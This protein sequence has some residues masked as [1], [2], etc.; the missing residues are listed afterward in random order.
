[1]SEGQTSVAGVAQTALPSAGGLLRQA[2]EAAGLHIAALAVS[3][4]M[5][6]R[7]IEALE[8]DRWD[9]LPDLAFV[10]ALAASVCRSL[11]IDPAPVLA[12]L[13]PASPARLRDS[14]S[15][16]GAS[17]GGGSGRL[18]NHGLSLIT[19]PLGAASLLLLAALAIYFWPAVES[20]VTADSTATKPAAPPQVSAEQA[21]SMSQ[22]AAPLIA[23]IAA[24]PGV[25]TPAPL[26]SPATN[27]PV[28][29]AMASVSFK[30]R[31]VS[32]VE[33]TDGREAVL[34]R[35][36]LQA[37]ENVAAEGSS[38]LV[39]VIGRANAVEVTVRGQ[40]FDVQAHA[41]DNVARF[42]VK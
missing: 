9:E 39:V 23:S 28:S 24:V 29:S 5:P 35:R 42:E 17:L 13:P 20:P 40:A 15:L 2:R 6:V 8:G 31:S 22:S 12:L 37:G 10:R 26:A 25:A 41:K 19:R 3:L 18:W 32:W 33:V 30:A 1:M 14:E 36:T 27:A 4:K 21:Q 38:P 7:K 11:R 34:V 16:G